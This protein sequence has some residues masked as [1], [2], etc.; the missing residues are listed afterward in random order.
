[1]KK[2]KHLFFDL[3]RT[4]WDF[5][6]NANEAYREIYEKYKLKELGVSGF[7]DFTKSYLKHNEVLWD[8]YRDGKI[9]KEYLRSRRFE[10]TLLDFGIDNPG[11]AEKIGM[12][13]VTISP[14]KTNLFPNAIEI[15][16]YLRPLYQMH[17]ITN[18]FEEVQFTK[19]KN[20]RLDHFFKHVITS[21]AAGCKKPDPRIF[22]YALEQTGAKANESLMI[23]DDYE[24][25]IRSAAEAGMDSVYFNPAR[26]QHNGKLKHE[27][28]D[29]IDLKKIL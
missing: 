14:Q 18:G 27:I 19:L 2:Y 26:L 24:V 3:D 29:L 13:Y 10:V 25:D 12:D 8:L 1:M 20:S 21:E 4:L 22:V 6:K 5:E 16:E 17:I 9:E 28:F 11:L 23:G 15:L 7:E